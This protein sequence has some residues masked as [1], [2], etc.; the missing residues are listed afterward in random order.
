MRG[1]FDPRQLAHAPA[2]ELHNGGFVAYAEKPARAEMIGHFPD[3]R[4][5]LH[6]A[7]VT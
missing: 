7:T 5:T 3:N 1:F 6:P 4:S 2:S